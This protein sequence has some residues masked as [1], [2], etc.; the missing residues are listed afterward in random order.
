MWG[1]PEPVVVGQEE[2]DKPGIS[3]RAEGMFG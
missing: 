2:E 3:E 1:D